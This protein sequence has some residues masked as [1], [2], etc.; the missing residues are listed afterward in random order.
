MHASNPPSKDKSGKPIDWTIYKGMIGPL[1]Y[2]T[3]RILD[4]MQSV[5]LCARFH[6]DP[7]ES[8]LK[9]VKRILCYLIGT[10]Y[11]CLFYKKIKI[12]KDGGT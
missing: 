10:T 8:H 4:I 2:L 9:D 6:S 11:Q 3:S 12:E 5:C 1:L 7:R